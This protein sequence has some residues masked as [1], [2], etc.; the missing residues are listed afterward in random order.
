MDLSGMAA[1]RQLVNLTEEDVNLPK[2]IRLLEIQPAN[3]TLELQNLTT[4]QM[5][6]SPQ[7]VGELQEGYRIK[8]MEIIPA[9]VDV[10]VPEGE[11]ALQTEL[12]TTPIYL[13]GIRSPTT[14]YCKIIT[15][16]GFQPRDKRW[17]D[18]SVRI[19]IE[20]QER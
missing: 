7:F 4:R 14:V 10:I 5:K 12:L 3:V 8:D 1:G 16:Y 19:N 11:E 9:Q 18:V 20:R 15:P 6:I 17:P 13:Q 2:K